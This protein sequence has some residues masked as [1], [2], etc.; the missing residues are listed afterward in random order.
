MKGEIVQLWVYLS[1]TPLFGL[2][3]TLV[4][5]LAAV[6]IHEKFGSKPI[7][8][9]VVIAVIMLVIMLSVTGMDYATYFDG[10]QF[11][12]FLL[13]PATV[14]LAVPLYRQMRKL[15]TV[16][17]PLMSAI[18]AGIISGGISAVYIAEFLG[19]SIETALS[20]APK[21][22]TAPVAMGIAEAIGGLPSLTAILVVTTGVIGAIIG[23]RLFDLIGC[24][25]DSVKGVA[26]GVTSHGIG[27]ARAFQVSS[28]MGAFS[29]LAMALSALFTSM[30]LPWL[31]TLMG[32]L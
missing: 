8:N 26:M 21:S 22:V 27:T 13:G 32:Y 4:A 12:H 15:R 19:A 16:F 24:N 14:A 30:L 17:F 11:I 20:L 10:A 3:A 6:K 5:Y 2:T 18:V 1:A 7:L 31:L 9:P 23:T 29:G 28:E 25:D